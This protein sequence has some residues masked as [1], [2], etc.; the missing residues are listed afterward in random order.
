M[1][2][3]R[4]QRVDHSTCGGDGRGAARTQRG[5]GAPRREAKGWRRGTGVGAAW[6]TALV[7]VLT[8]HAHAV[9]LDV[10]RVPQAAQVDTAD[11]LAPALTARPGAP[12]PEHGPRMRPAGP[13][14]GQAPVGL[15][16]ALARLRIFALARVWDELLTMPAPGTLGGPDTRLHWAHLID[17]AEGRVAFRRA[18]TVEAGLGPTYN[19][20]ACSSCHTQPV[21]GGAGMGQA[22]AIFVRAPDHDP[23]DTISPRKFSIPGVPLEPRGPGK[24]LRR[25]PPLFGLGRLDAIPDADLQRYADPEDRDKDGVR[26]FLNTR[27]GRDGVARPARFGHKSNESNLLRF[28]AGALHNEM[29][30]TNPMSRARPK[31]TDAVADP[32]ASGRYVAALDAYVRGLAPPPRGAITP[33][34]RAGEFIFAMVGCASCHRAQVGDVRTGVRGA[35][36]DL[37]LHDLGPRLSDGLTDAKAG[38]THWRTAPLWGLR[39]R[40]GLLHD[41]RTTD[42]HEAIVLHGGEASGSVQRYKALQPAQRDKLLAFL[43]SL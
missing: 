10:R 19:Q 26:G 27:H 8:S 37:L 5:R 1:S 42:V 12:W 23:N 32:E 40:S 11:P 38:P 9:K 21:L 28:L 4:D 36:T 3:D 33:A 31:D 24:Q 20:V 16:G 7:V 2:D 34:V 35:Y 18:F 41:A 6:A 22:D 13:A 43:A 39:H 17:F 15:V 29:G 14:A 25:T 30:V